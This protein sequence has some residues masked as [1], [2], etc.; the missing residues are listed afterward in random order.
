MSQLDAG[1]NVEIICG[2]I[3]CTV[4][5][6][7]LDLALSHAFN[8]L[9][10]SAILSV[11]SPPSPA[12]KTMATPHTN[13]ILPIPASATQK[14]TATGPV[15]PFTKTTTPRLKIVIRS[16]PPA[17]TSAEFEAALGDQWKVHGGKVDWAMYKEGKVSKE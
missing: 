13:G 12:I 1:N 17:L 16:L 8:T 10:Q 11:W 15:K 3:V 4:N 7:H 9:S 5:L 14:R 6:K 2:V